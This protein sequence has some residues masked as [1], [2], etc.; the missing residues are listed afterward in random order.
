MTVQTP[1]DCYME[2]KKTSSHIIQ[3]DIAL[4]GKQKMILVDGVS[5]AEGRLY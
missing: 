5:L 2:A 1:G 4:T 3:Q